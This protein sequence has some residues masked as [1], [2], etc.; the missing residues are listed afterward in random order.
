VAEYRAYAVGSDGNFNGFEPLVCADD[1]KAIEEAK[2]LLDGC[3]IEL[4]CGTRLVIRL[5]HEP[6]AIGTV[7]I[8]NVM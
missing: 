1:A 6:T 3:D 2:R 7:P 5:T 4:W 8:S